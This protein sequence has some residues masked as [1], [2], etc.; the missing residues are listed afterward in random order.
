MTQE[1]I[2]L[3][4]IKQ[5]QELMYNLVLTDSKPEIVSEFSSN[6]S[7]RMDADDYFNFTRTL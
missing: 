3:L 7:R 4:S 5:I 2:D 1:I 6:L